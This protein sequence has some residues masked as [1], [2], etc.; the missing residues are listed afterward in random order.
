LNLIRKFKFGHGGYFRVKLCKL[1]SPT[2][3]VTGACFDQNV[4]KIVNFNYTSPLFTSQGGTP[5]ASRYDDATI[6]VSYLYN[7]DS[8]LSGDSLTGYVSFE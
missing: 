7:S 2:D 4:L 1:N 6:Y 8:N 3:T 5:N